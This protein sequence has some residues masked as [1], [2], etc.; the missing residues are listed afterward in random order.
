[1]TETL[2]MK[3]DLYHDEIPLAVA[4]SLDELAQMCGVK[5]QSIIQTMSRAKRLK[6]RCCYIVIDAPK[7]KTR[8]SCYHTY[9]NKLC[10]KSNGKWKCMNYRCIKPLDY[11][12][13]GIKRFVKSKTVCI[14]MEGGR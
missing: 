8:C 13:K 10:I 5:K 11:N 2:W 3:V 7:K 14:K 6:H 9:P 4:D 12:T 1:M